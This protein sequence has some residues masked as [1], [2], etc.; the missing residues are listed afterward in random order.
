MV[1]FRVQNRSAR[2]VLY[3]R[4]PFHFKAPLATETR[5]IPCRKLPINIVFNMGY[6]PILLK[7]GFSPIGAVGVK[8]RGL[9]LGDWES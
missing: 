5:Y 8:T 1:F 2:V 6:P 9:E 3:P 4:S 7:S